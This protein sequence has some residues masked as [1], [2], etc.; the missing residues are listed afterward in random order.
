MTH[1]LNGFLAASLAISCSQLFAQA[2]IPENIQRTLTTFCADCHSGW[3]PDG[4]I[5][6]DGPIVDWD[7]SVSRKEWELVHTMVS[8]GIMP[9][10]ESESL[11][12]ADR[13]ELLKWLHQELESHSPVGGTPLR[14]LSAR[15]YANTIRSLFRLPKFE[16]PQS[17]PPDNGRDGFDN[18]GSELVIAVS[19]L[20]ALA[21]TATAVAD[22][23]FA[24]PRPEVESQEFTIPADDLVISY[25]SACLINGTMRLA[26]SG[27]NI[28]RNATWPSRFEAPAH[29]RYTI[30]LTASAFR[31]DGT[32]PNL[33]VSSMTADRSL[34]KVLGDFVLSG[35]SSERLLIEATLDRGETIVMQYTNGPLK[36]DDKKIF[37]EY[38]TEFLADEP[39]LAA[40][41]AKV[42]N[43]PRGG[44]GWERVKEAMKSDDLNLSAYGKGSETVVQ[45]AKKLASN[46]VNT[47]ETLV[48]RFF[49]EGPAIAIHGVNI[50]GPHEC[51]VDRDDVR[52]ERQRKRLLGSASDATRADE[53]DDFFDEF[54]SQAFRRPATESEI[55]SYLEIV[56]RET[57][58]T[59]DINRG[60]H[61][62][63][64]TALM[65][66]TF[67]YRN[68]SH[69]TQTDFPLAS[70]LSYFLTSG[71]PD[72]KL[73]DIAARGRLAD[74]KTL[75]REANRIISPAFTRDFTTQWLG[76]EVL[77]NLMPDTRLIRKFTS[78]HRETMRKEVEATFQHV[79]DSNLPVREL[80]S[81]DFLFTDA[82][83]G[84]DIYELDQ[85]RPAKKAAK[86]KGQK[87]LQQVA[88]DRDSRRGGLLS[89]PAVMM[90]TANGV[91][92]QPV[93]RGVWVLEN[94][95]GSPPPEPPNAVPALTPDITGASTPKGRLAA[96]MASD[97]CAV[98]HR[99]IDP[100]GFVL[101]NYDPVG[102]WRDHY[103]KYLDQPTGRAKVENGAAVDTQGVLPNGVP[104]SDVTDLKRWLAENPEP[105]ARCLSE[106]L[107]TYAT[108]RELSFRERAM[109]AK[110]VRQNAA[111]E[112]RLRD[113]MFT[114]ID[115]DIFRTR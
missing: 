5:R 1:S 6:L 49:E 60:L 74:T 75:V 11:P 12:D 20:A 38:L 35:E 54:L 108:G 13:I 110:I 109:I 47:G 87:K 9:P 22:E 86:S 100:L 78:S 56:R 10:P 114:L 44:S 18:Q 23:F 103:P 81:P 16:L 111:N 48:Y 104:L 14:R 17:F 68:L 65:S 83:V 8:K 4:E 40:A 19:H 97:G 53:L 41:W 43:P 101:E 59:G 79:L 37:E 94:I 80:I 113:L 28:I 115:S 69:G 106:K 96:H 55:D 25:S 34:S 91:D 62:A 32:R 90:A 99:E 33:R 63:L 72:R 70:R 21:D 26:S 27:N 66:P 31:P 39:R 98:C 76:L 2:E 84:W 3:Q 107:M 82:L 77:D 24:P 85:F 46:N 29:G 51:F 93:L 102:R 30:E 71:P 7:E 52:I 42:G 36:Y 73:V 57:N 58:A 112:Y 50:T 15:E 67:L 105:F 88:I 64:R 61:L 45:M 95:L 89:M 92:T